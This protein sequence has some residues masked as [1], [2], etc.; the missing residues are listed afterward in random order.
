M[1][2]DKRTPEPCRACGRHH[3]GQIASTYT[4]PLRSC[5]ANLESKLSELE[6]ENKRLRGVGAELAIFASYLLGENRH[7]NDW[8]PV[9]D[10]RDN[11][12]LRNRGH[13]KATYGSV[14]EALRSEVSND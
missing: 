12:P 6:A 1:I 2:I 11:P 5:I 9:P 3:D 10:G 8:F 7:H 13:D 14:L 4:T